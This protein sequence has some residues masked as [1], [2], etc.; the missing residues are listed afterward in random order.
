MPHSMAILQSVIETDGWLLCDA[1]PLQC[2]HCGVIYYLH[3]SSDMGPNQLRLCRFMLL[4]CAFL[5]SVSP[6]CV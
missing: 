4:D 6:G 2:S 1:E 5:I 3:F